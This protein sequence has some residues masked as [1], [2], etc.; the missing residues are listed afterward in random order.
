M[1]NATSPCTIRFSDP[2]VL[3]LSSPTLDLVRGSNGPYDVQVEI[4]FTNVSITACTRG[5]GS[6]PSDIIVP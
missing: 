4:G 1:F 3:G 2:G 6:D 5:A